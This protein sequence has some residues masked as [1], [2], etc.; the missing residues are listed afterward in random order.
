MRMQ[1]EYEIFDYLGNRWVCSI[2]NNDDYRDA[3][4]FMRLRCRTLGFDRIMDTLND[5]QT[6]LRVLKFITTYHN[7]ASDDKKHPITI[8]HDTIIHM[9]DDIIV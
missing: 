8:A 6:L 1:R 4:A 7:S 9:N 5:D 3:P 2:H